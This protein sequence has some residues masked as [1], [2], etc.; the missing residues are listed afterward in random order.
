MLAAELPTLIPAPLQK[1]RAAYVRRPP[2]AHREHPGQHPRQHRPPLRPV[3]RA[4]PAVP[5]RHVELLLGDLRHLAG[6]PRRPP[7]GR[8]AGGS[9]QR[10]AARGPGP[11][12]RAAARP[13]AGRARAPGCSRSAPAGASWRSAPPRAVPPCTRSPCP[14]SSWTLAEERI[15]EAGLADQVTVE[16][17]DYRDVAGQLRRRL[18]VEMIE[19]VGHEYWPTY[20]RT[21]DRL[22]AP[23]R[24]RRH[25]G[26][27]DAARPDAGHPPH[28]HVDQQVHLPRRLP[29]VG[30]RRS[31]RSPAAHT[32]LRISERLSFGQHYAE[33]LRA[34]GPGV[35]RRPRPQVLGL[36]FD[37][38]FVRMWHFYLEYSRAGF[39]SGLHRRQPDRPGAALV[40]AGGRP[41]DGSLR[42]HPRDPGTIR[43]CVSRGCRAAAE[44]S[45]AALRRRRPPGAPA[46]VGRLGGRSGGRAR[47]SSSARRD[48]VRRLLWHPG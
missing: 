7:A 14:R 22:L 30:R 33:T 21:I 35:P 46:G 37:E 24:T 43:P 1:L 44:R 16:L 19:A 15:A 18:S 26:D 4:V 13:D 42:S 20:F 5:R 39:A 38:T 34:V 48:A 8:A 12:D 29:A 47:W 3:Q 32:R 2:R 9:R 45:A 40:S 28:V 11:Q 41:F 27:H 23:G 17:S 25:P 31:T 36:G 6:R 10:V